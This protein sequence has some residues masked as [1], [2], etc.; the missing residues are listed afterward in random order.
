MRKLTNLRSKKERAVKTLDKQIEKTEEAIV[1]LLSKR[2]GIVVG[3]RYQI[4]SKLSARRMFVGTVERVHLTHSSA[5]H[6][7][8]TVLVRRE[9]RRGGILGTEWVYT[10]WANFH[11][12]EDAS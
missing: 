1:A 8:L 3:G 7:S 6:D 4:T 5:D 11:R 12:I 10:G 2:E 9:K